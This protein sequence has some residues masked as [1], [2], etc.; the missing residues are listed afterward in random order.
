MTEASKIVNEISFTSQDIAEYQKKGI[1]PIRK[2]ISPSVINR[3]RET[4]DMNVKSETKMTKFRPAYFNRADNEFANKDELFK[5]IANELLAPLNKLTGME[6]GAT[7]V[8]LFEL[9]AGKSKGFKWHF[10]TFSFSFIDKD[11]A[12]HTIWIPLD[13]IYVNKQDGG[14]KWVHQNDFSAKEQFRKWAHLQLLDDPKALDR[15]H[16]KI[17]NEQFA[18]GEHAGFYDTLMMEDLK[19]DCDLEVGD[20]LFFHRYTWHRSQELSTNGPLKRRGA[21]VIR[22]IDLDGK[23]DLTLFN[24]RKNRKIQANGG[25]ATSFAD[26]LDAFKDGDLL[27]DAFAAGISF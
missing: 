23:L 21:L 2:L 1:I 10:G 3:I 24:K 25:A 4:I 11:V 12:A 7:Q 8:G 20:A 15:K 6:L 14:M 5:I 22:F 17:Y 13:P 16:L 9:E 19:Q 18:Y 26:R 27:R